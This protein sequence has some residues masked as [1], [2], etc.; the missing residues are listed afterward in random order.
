M[1]NMRL[2][3]IAV[4]LTCRPPPCSTHT[5]FSPLFLIMNPAVTGS[6]P[7]RPVGREG[8]SLAC[9]EVNDSN[10]HQVRR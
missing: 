4:A 3:S 7:G 5:V 9:C 8:Y 1:R 10:R 6:M 2:K